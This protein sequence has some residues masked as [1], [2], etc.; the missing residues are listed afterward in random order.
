MRE[1]HP[2][3]LESKI[4]IMTNYLCCLVL[5][6]LRPFVLVVVISWVPLEWQ[7]PKT[8]FFEFNSG[9]WVSWSNGLWK[10]PQKDLVVARI[11]Q[12]HPFLS[13]PTIDI[14]I[15]Q[16][17]DGSNQTIMVVQSSSGSPNQPSATCFNVAKGNPPSTQ[18]WQFFMSKFYILSFLLKEELH[19]KSENCFLNTSHP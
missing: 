19:H 10:M 3:T 17:Q 13:W 11:S 6:L 18:I 14:Y 12:G 15:N 16:S 8:D 7:I 5:P 1:N 9:V 4:C 2:S